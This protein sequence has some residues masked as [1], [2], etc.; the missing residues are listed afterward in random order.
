[1]TEE[2]KTMRVHQYLYYVKCK[3]VWSDYD[4]DAFCKKHGLDGGGG[5]DRESDYPEDIKKL[6]ND[7]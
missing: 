4:Y 2:E 7:L 6:A 3:P 5:S 1:M